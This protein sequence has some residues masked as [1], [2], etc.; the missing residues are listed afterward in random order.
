MSS[1][2]TLHFPKKLIIRILEDG[3]D[4]PLSKIAVTLT[5][6][7]Q[8][9]NDY[10]LGPPLSHSDGRIIIN[11]IWVN[12]AINH[13]RNSF[14]MDYSSTMEQCSP[15]IRIT[16][17]STDDIERAKSAM[18]LYGIE[19]GGEEVDHSISDLNTANNKDYQPREEFI[20]LDD[21]GEESKEVVIKLTRSKQ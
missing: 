18:K 12:N 15:E 6:H 19:N 2:R 1:S 21:P 11:Q 10:H 13:L 14:L 17:M 5:I 8:A 7:A 3:T 9:K 4:Y 20:K 16:V